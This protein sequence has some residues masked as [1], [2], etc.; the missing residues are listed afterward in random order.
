MGR[1]RTYYRFAF[2]YS[3]QLHG[4]NTAITEVLEKLSNGF[5]KYLRILTHMRGEYLNLLQSLSRGE[6]YHLE[7][8]VNE[9]QRH[10]CL[11][12]K[13]D[14]LLDLYLEWKQSQDASL[15]PRIEMLRR[16]IRELVPDLDFKIPGL[17]GH[18]A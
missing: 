11:N 12:S 16:E 7:R 13:Q 3:E 18:A 9:G 2:S 6:V 5:D 8:V 17:E 10:Q 1:G 14:E 4:R 15:L